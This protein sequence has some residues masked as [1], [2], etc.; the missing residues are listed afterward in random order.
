V[1]WRLN[2][3]GLLPKLDRIAAVS[4]GAI[5]AA[6]L[7]VVWTRLTFGADGVARNLEHEV[8][9][10]VR[11]LARKT[12]DTKAVVTGLLRP[13]ENAAARLAHGLR[14]LYGDATL[15][16]LPDRPSF[17]VTATSLQTGG[18]WRF[19]KPYMAD[20]FVGRIPH[21][22]VSIADAVVASSVFAPLG[23]FALDLDPSE[24]APDTT[25]W[26][27]NPS[28]RERAYLVD[29]S[30]SDPLAIETAWAR[31]R[32]VL[33]SDGTGA[34][35]PIQDPGNWINQ[36]GRSV[37][38]ATAQ[39]RV[40]RKRQA[41]AA[42]VAG[43]REGAF[44]A[45]AGDILNQGLPDALP[46]PLERTRSLALLPSRFSALDDATQERLINWG[47]AA[48]DAAMRRHVVPHAPPPRGFPY[49][50]AGV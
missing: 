45:I 49:P 16:A 36:F 33:I 1:L 7:G 9:A 26:L 24:F 10:P 27:D 38:L 5:T 43:E 11:S 30:L 2:E 17:V 15:A 35:Q 42:F 29:G 3:L 13:G 40:L 37:S 34:L 32:T 19:S 18:L 6:H 39:S 28:Y 48:C 25:G 14:A 44:W 20:A 50:A 4:G 22:R 8:V 41:V 46:A 21:P 31:Y 12:L 47:Y 23:P